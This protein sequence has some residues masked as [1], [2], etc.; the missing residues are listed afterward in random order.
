MDNNV[1][2]VPALCTQCGGTVE[3]NKDDETA[4][5]P[6]CGT[7]F[8]VEKAINNYNIDVSGAVKEVLDFAGDQMEAKRQERSERRK[9]EA[10]KEKY[11]FKIFGYVFAGMLVFALIVFIILQFTG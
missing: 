11:F 6:F 7:S 2:M 8:I 3:V 5:C 10:E 1:K 4:V 9:E